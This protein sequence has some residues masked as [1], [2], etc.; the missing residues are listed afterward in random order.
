MAAPTLHIEDATVA[1]VRTGD[2]FA[3][4]D[5]PEGIQDGHLLLMIFFSWRGS[6]GWDAAVPAPD[7]ADGFSLVLEGFTSAGRARTYVYSKIADEEPASY[8]LPVPA[9][10]DE[11]YYCLCVRVTGYS[12]SQPFGPDQ[13]TAQQSSNV[14]SVTAA[15]VSNATS[16]YLLI[17]TAHFNRPNVQTSLGPTAWDSHPAGMSLA[18][19]IFNP[20][21]AGAPLAGLA[22]QVLSSATTGTRQW[23]GTGGTAHAAASLFT[24]NAGQGGLGVG[25]SGRAAFGNASADLVIARA[26]D[27]SPLD[28]AFPEASGDWEMS[29][30]P[31]PVL[32]EAYAFNPAAWVGL[33]APSAEVD[34]GDVL[35][36]VGSS[37]GLALRCIQAGTTA[38]TAPGWPSAPGAQIDDGTSRWQVLGRVRDLAPVIN[39]YVAGA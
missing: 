4:V 12:E 23:T 20:E 29:V 39:F 3:T 11:G 19:E 31:G 28:L 13:S 8:D 27:G 22:T 25:I 21:S 16:D 10:T 32:L 38:A 9:V 36:T 34:A 24:I 26:V 17:S 15:S 35:F 2:S 7:A 18:W 5:A 6:T 14:T 37:D 30:P 1:V 33:W